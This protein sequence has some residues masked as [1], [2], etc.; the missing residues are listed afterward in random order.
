[1]SWEKEVDSNIEHLKQSLNSVS[2]GYSEH[3]HESLFSNLKYSI[4]LYFI[5]TPSPDKERL[6]NW[7]NSISELEELAAN[8]KLESMKLLEK[9]KQGKKGVSKYLSY[10]K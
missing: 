6:E 8:L 2:L 4:E 3:D 7:L 10:S 5:N 1:M 9:R